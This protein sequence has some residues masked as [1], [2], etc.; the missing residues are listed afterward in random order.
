MC[1]HIANSTAQDVALSA[2]LDLGG[3]EAMPHMSSGP[4]ST[5]GEGQHVAV[6]CR[7]Y[8]KEKRELSCA[9]ARRSPNASGAH[10]RGASVRSIREGCN[11]VARSRPH[12]CRSQ[13]LRFLL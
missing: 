1:T 2:M 3:L 4:W 11:T 8:R 5:S 13:R 12:Q 10:N 6:P 7:M 9:D